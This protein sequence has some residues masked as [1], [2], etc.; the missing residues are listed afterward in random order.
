[1]W[2]N[3]DPLLLCLFT[4]SLGLLIGFLICW[5]YYR[6]KTGGIQQLSQAIIRQA[7]IE[8][9]T[10]KKNQESLLK[11]NQ[12]LQQKELESHWQQEKRKIQREEERFK[13]REDKLEHRQN[14][15]DKKVSDLEKREAA[16]TESKIQLELKLV[17]LQ[18]TRASLIEELE[19][20]AGLSAQEARE[21]LKA[22]I[23]NE[24]KI[25]MAHL[26][27]RSVKEAEETAEKEAARIIATAITR[28]AVPC[29]NE[30]TVTTV[31]IPSDEMKGRIIGKEGRNIRTFE[32]A[33]GITLIIDDTP[34]AIV[35]SGFDPIRMQI[36]KIALTDLV[37]DGR[38][39][40]TRIEE[41]VGKAKQNMQSL[42]KKYGEE[43]VLRAGA[44][45]MS[46]D[47]I[48]LLGKLKFRLSFGQ[49]VLDHSLEVSHLMSLM[50]AELGLD[51]T[52]ARRIGL[53]HDIGKAVSHEVEG[54]HA[55]VG[56]DL[57][58]RYGESQEV[59]N[60]IGC[61]HF[62]IEARTIEASLCSAADAISASRQG[63]RSEP[64]E[65]YIKRLK[66][67]E[68]LALQFP[69]VEKAYAMQAGR[70]IRVV[71]KP[72]LIDDGGTLCLARE[73]TKKIEEELCYQGKIKVT[74]IREMRAIDYAVKQLVH[75][76]PN[77]K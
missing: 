69:A 40:P 74:V 38:I 6:L 49:N 3:S 17:Q 73:L 43:A 34:N 53:L 36:A 31:A 18:A 63:A 70:E 2:L 15:A 66:K 52:L 64:V 76:A 33:T 50:A 51:S 61:H 7:E 48:L 12:A 4:L 30:A 44:I 57:A 8:V 37:Q 1:M 19:K 56:R 68:A 32:Q 58:L 10:L 13:Q 23:S 27:R 21:L 65:H 45:N 55:L 9:E 14:L 11:K 54:S 20:L 67:L 77:A 24:I 26:W 71:V 46:A 60:G 22:K 62:E 47:L 16:L 75:I 59:A 41:I 72:S 5:F 42:I 35:L 28:L 39:H 25:E 29:V